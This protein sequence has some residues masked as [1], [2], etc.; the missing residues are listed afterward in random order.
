MKKILKF[1][2]LYF[3]IAAGIILLLS[4]F[5]FHPFRT[6]TRNTHIDKLTIFTEDSNGKQSLI[7]ETDS[8]IYNRRFT[9]L[10]DNLSGNCHKWHIP[11]SFYLSIN[12]PDKTVINLNVPHLFAIPVFPPLMDCDFLNQL[13][14][15][16]GGKLVNGAVLLD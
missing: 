13:I 6:K 10:K 16:W 2:K 1:H 12:L 7:Y 5:I 9:L 15:K 14:Q 4:L 3:L 8:N 11:H